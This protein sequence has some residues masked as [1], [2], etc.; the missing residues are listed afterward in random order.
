MQKLRIYIMINF[1]SQYSKK[2]R[3]EV[4][5]EIEKSGE[6]AEPLIYGEL[7]NVG[8]PY[9]NLSMFFIRSLLSVS[10]SVLNCC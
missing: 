7:E 8:R 2:E 1:G 10:L 9:C 3:I 4:N 6:K 5:A